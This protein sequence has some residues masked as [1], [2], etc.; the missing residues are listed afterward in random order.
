MAA[1]ALAAAP[2]TAQT[3]A[4]AEVDLELVLAVDVSRSM[5]FEEQRVQRDG[6]VA[7]F[8]DPEL[9]RAVRDGAIGRIA[10]I[11]LEW[12]GPTNQEV[13]VPWTVIDGAASANAFADR[14]A[15]AP[16]ERW[17]GTSISGGLEFAERQFGQGGVAGLRRVV[18]VSGDGPNNMG[19]GVTG[20]RDRLVS[21]GIV[22]N[23][24]PLILKDR[25]DAYRTA[26]LGDYYREC[27]VGGTGS[28]VIEVADINQFAAAVRRKLILEIADRGWEA[29]PVRRVQ[30]APKVDCYIGEKQRGF[31]P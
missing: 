13:R 31:L 18:D 6:Y 10:V 8:R 16:I 27:V 5:D 1:C 19:T 17:N 2:A 15:G 25:Y 14:L 4:A 26:H 11:Y 21:K 7:A 12:S 24:L 29:L 3:R 9:I 30:A 23:G 22:I 28:F 20:M